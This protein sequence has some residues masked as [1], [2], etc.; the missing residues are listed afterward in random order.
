MSDDAQVEVAAAG[1]VGGLRRVVL[2]PLSS[3]TPH[4]VQD[5]TAGSLEAGSLGRNR[6]VPYFMK[7]AFR[8]GLRAA[9]E[10][11]LAGFIRQVT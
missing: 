11:V 1:H 4:T 5:R 8:L 6:T 3:G 10:E 9:L 2:V 7:G